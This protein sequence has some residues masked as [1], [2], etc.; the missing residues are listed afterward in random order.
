MLP[1]VVHEICEHCGRDIEQIIAE[2]QQAEAV[3]E[4]M[5]HVREARAMKF[6]AQRE[7]YHSAAAHLDEMRRAA[8]ETACAPPDEDEVPPPTAAD[9]TD[10]NS[11]ALNV[12]FE[13]PYDMNIAK[14]YHRE[15]RTLLLL[16]EDARERVRWSQ[17]PVSL[18]FGFLLCSLSRPALRLARSFLPLPSESTLYRYFGH[19]INEQEANIEMSSKIPTRIDLFMK[20]SGVQPGDVVSVAVDAMAMSPDR[21]CLAAHSSDY[22]LVFYAQPLARPNKCLALHVHKGASGQAGKEVQTL[23]DFICDMLSQRGIQVRYV[24]S[25]GDAGY[26]KRHHE[27]FKTWY[28][29]LL[30]KGICGALDVLDAATKMPVSDFLH[31]WKNFCNKVKNHPV[32][33]CPELPE[34]VVTVQ[35]LQS[36]LQLGTTLS[37]KT[38]IGKMRD[39]YPLQ[40]FS[41]ANCAECAEQGDDLALLYLLPWAL[42]EEVIRNPALTRPERLDKALLSFNLLLHYFDLS[43]LPRSEGITQ[44]F[45][46][47]QTV[48]VTFAED[49]VWPRILNNALILIHFIVVAPPDWS[50]SRLGTHCRMIEP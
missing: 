29:P 36:L 39:S 12:D 11:E 44:R 2:E 18:S 34:D 1:D 35:D 28:L 38:S 31:L 42:Q 4:R 27:F 30:Q 50:F 10:A 41:F 37:D 7:R 32:T 24:C 8:A 48:A 13:L 3:R 6:Q 26:N 45:Q 14:V 40:L 22:L 20:L 19:D 17:Y 21:S 15:L 49:S 43:F 33:L 16:D 9:P 25:D 23:L 5:A 46:R 47:K